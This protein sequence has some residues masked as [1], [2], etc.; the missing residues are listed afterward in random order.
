MM[1]GAR[2]L[3]HA[4]RILN[5]HTGAEPPVFSFIGAVRSERQWV[6]SFG[7]NSLLKNPLARE[8]A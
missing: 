6:S 7:S 5:E 2:G 4:I 8:G 3:L 1:S